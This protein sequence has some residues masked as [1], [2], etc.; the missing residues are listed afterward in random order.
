[1]SLETQL[2]A[3]AEKEFEVR[4]Y[5]MMEAFNKQFS[6][7]TQCPFES[8]P[9]KANGTPLENALHTE[10]GPLYRLRYNAPKGSNT[11]IVRNH[12]RE[13]FVE[14]FI[15]QFIATVEASQEF[16]GTQE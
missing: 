10:I 7:L 2:R 16:L 12:F 9:A 8:H 13:K 1:M 6:E 11:E 5:A 4:W 15:K 3:K 14:H